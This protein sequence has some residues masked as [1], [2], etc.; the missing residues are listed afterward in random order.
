VC[1]S[2]LSTDPANNKR[3]PIPDR[4]AQSTARPIRHVW[5][6]HA[7]LDAPYPSPTR[8]FRLT[9][10]TSQP[11]L[12]T[13]PTTTKRGT[14]V[15]MAETANVSN[16]GTFNPAI[17]R[18]SGGGSNPFSVYTLSGAR[19]TPRK[20]V[21]SQLFEE[22]FDQ[23]QPSTS[24]EYWRGSSSV[25]KPLRRCPPRDSWQSWSQTT[26]PR[27]PR[28]TQ[29]Y[30]DDDSCGQ[31]HTAGT[32]SNNHHRPYQAICSPDLAEHIDAPMSRCVRVGWTRLGWATR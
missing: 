32:P 29:C 9:R 20:S 18:R 23:L 28:P 15:T 31:D 6:R 3:E 1:T 2:G 19:R 21:H 14:A 4:R 26:R 13:T 10:R 11:M 16:P 27:A 8:R 17:S 5:I 24:S 25:Q 30:G 7:V 12:A 22:S